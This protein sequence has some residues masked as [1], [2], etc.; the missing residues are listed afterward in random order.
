MGKKAIAKFTFPNDESQIERITKALICLGLGT[1][2]LSFE[3]LS[4]EVQK[5]HGTH[6]DFMEELLRLEFA[7]KEDSRVELRINRAKLTPVVNLRELSF[8]KQ[9]SIDPVLVNDLASCRY[10]KEGKNVIILGPPGVGKTYLANGL[11]YEAILQGRTTRCMKKDECITAINSSSEKAVE[12]LFKMLAAPNLLVVDDIDYYN[13]DDNSGQIIHDILKYRYEYNLSTIITSNN[14]PVEWLKLFGNNKVRAAA[15]LDRLMDHS[16][17]YVINI[18]GQSYRVPDPGIMVDQISTSVDS[19][20]T[21][22][23]ERKQIR[24]LLNHL[25]N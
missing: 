21:V 5:S 20:S 9:P 11:C 23:L 4:K 12:R 6:F 8:K 3:Y 14:N 15:L 18:K 10:I 1:A 17:A 19:K 16:R 24:S 13:N 25:I 7:Q 2:A 22:K